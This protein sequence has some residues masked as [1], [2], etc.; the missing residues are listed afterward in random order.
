MTEEKAIALGVAMGRRQA[1][2]RTAAFLRA[3]LKS[4]AARIANRGPLIGPL[5]AGAT[6]SFA[7]DLEREAAEIDAQIVVLQSEERRART[8][9]LDAKREHDAATV[10]RKPWWKL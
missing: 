10:K 6:R 7:A 5:L 8:A 1:A 4:W 9:L 3:L 2:E